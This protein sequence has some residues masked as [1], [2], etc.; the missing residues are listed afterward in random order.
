MEKVIKNVV[1]EI[2]LWGW[3]MLNFQHN[4]EG[5]SPKLCA[6]TG[7]GSCFF[8]EPGFHF[9][10]P[11]PPVLFDQPLIETQIKIRMAKQLYNYFEEDRK[12]S[13]LKRLRNRDDQKKKVYCNIVI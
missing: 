7:G 4:V 13:R 10:R 3:V 9:L 6:T 5:G 12:A 2:E 11:T 8:E 1:L